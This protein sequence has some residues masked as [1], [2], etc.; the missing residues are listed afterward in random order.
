MLNYGK[1]FH[2]LRDKKNKYS[3]SRVLNE[4]KNHNLPFKLNGR[5]L[6]KFIPS[7]GESSRST[8][9]HTKVFAVLYTF[10]FTCFV[11]KFMT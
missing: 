9:I 1:Q 11:L 6:I 4:T 8:K 2:A 5:S 3:N 7:I 10:K